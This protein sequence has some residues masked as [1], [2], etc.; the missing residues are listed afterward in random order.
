[1]IAIIP[2][3]DVMDGKCVRLSQGD[4]SRKK[5]YFD[6]P[7]EVAKRFEDSGITRLHLVDLDGAKAGRLINFKTIERIANRT[8]LTIDFGGGLRTDKDVEIAFECGAKQI[9][10]GSVAAKD[11]ELVYGWLERYG[12]EAVILGADVKDEKISVS[13]WQEQSELEVCE[14][15]RDYQTSGIKF[16][17]C[18]EI[19]L[20]GMLLGPAFELYKKL[21]SEVEGINLIASG[22]VSS[23]DD[24]EKLQSARLHG[25]IIGKAIYEGRIKLSELKAFL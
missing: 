9:T 12:S 3:I 11:R 4:F 20:D 24:I 15:L 22:G 21:L 1:M 5:T 8:R 10:A 14:Y 19:S 2:A 23:L 18:T 16:V 6:D 25:V 7:L 17:I 13:G